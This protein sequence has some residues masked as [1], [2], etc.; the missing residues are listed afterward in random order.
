M[1]NIIIIGSS[2]HAKS[3]IDI[4]EKANEFKIIG[5]LD[6]FRKAGEYTLNYEILGTE[7]DLPK[8]INRHNTHGII[9]GIGDNYTRAKITQN[10]KKTF[11]ELAFITAVHPHTSIA[12]HVT[13]GAGSVIMA[14]S[15]IGVC[16][17][18]GEGCILNTN[19]SLD[20]DSTMDSFSSLAPSVTIGGDCK[21]GRISAICIGST[22]SHKVHIGENSILGAG[23][24]A[25]KNIPANALA[26]GSPAKI[27]RT[28][29]EGEKYL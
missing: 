1:K 3:I 18:I 4:I 5:L 2:G 26:Y 16:A 23:S 29:Q 9:V 24:I 28:R 11:P 19:S 14:G 6:R 12:N 8:L 25:L 21:I 7:E 27:V 22:V 20:H 17:S 15:N 10:I 13:I